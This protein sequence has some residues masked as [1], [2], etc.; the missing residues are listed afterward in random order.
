MNDAIKAQA[1]KLGFTVIEVVA[2]GDAQTQN[3]QIQSLITQ[4]VSAILVCAV[5]QNT[6]ERALMEAD[7][8]G[9]PVVAY[10]RALPDSKAVDAF[11]GPDSISD[12]RL[13]GGLIA[14]KLAGATSDV[15][16]LEL[17]G[18]LNDQNG[19]D[20]SAG[21]NE[22]VATNAHIKVVQIPTDWDSARALSGTQ[23]AFQANPDIKAVFAAT[24]TQFPAVE[25]VLTDL[26]KQIPAGQDGHVVVTG[27]NG[28]NDGYQ[29]VVKGTA[30]GFV[31]MD[32]ALTGAT[33]VNLADKLIKG[34][35]VEMV[36]VIPGV[37]Y[38][39]ADVEANKAKIWG[40]K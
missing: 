14:E 23:N 10:D 31:V 32:L 29:G 19:I 38:T 6:I 37:L 27:I 16:V 1:E 25:T 24:D 4:H 22:A 21:F 40:A 5:D 18:A 3:A 17:V 12:G 26:G 9:I 2:D 11:V 36:N 8:A 33:A 13:A 34:E 39:S 30:D 28:S 20:R 35:A 15:T 7:R